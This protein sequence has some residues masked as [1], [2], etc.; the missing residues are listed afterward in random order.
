MWPLELEL[1]ESSWIYDRIEG[2]PPRGG[3]STTNQSFLLCL[4]YICC[5]KL[6]ECYR[7]RDLK[8]IRLS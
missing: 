5:F 1:T 2:R 6:N 7:F 4:L 3:S 8:E